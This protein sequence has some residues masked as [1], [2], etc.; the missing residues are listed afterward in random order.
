MPHAVN[1]LNLQSA[2][3]RR[4]QGRRN[5]MVTYNNHSGLGNVSTGEGNTDE[6]VSAELNTG[7]INHLGHDQV[8]LETQSRDEIFQVNNLIKNSQI[9]NDDTKI[10]NRSRAANR[11]IPGS[12]MQTSS[13]VG[14]D[15]N[16]IIVNSR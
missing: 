11:R 15:D 1:R 14:H 12:E 10:E 13:F 8:N 6:F 3:P 5:Q 4:V 9:N 7:N 2:D 16:K